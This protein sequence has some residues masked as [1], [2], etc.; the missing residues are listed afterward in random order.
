MEYIYKLGGVASILVVI[1]S[2]IGFCFREKIKTYFQKD[3]IK[4]Q[5]KCVQD[6]ETYKMCLIRDLEK[7][8]LD[9]DVRKSM[10]IEMS[11]KK[12]GAYQK[13]ITGLLRFSNVV[14]T[15]NNLPAPERTIKPFRDNLNKAWQFVTDL[16]ESYFYYA[17]KHR[18][19]MEPLAKAM[20]EIFD[21]TKT[22]KLIDDTLSEQYKDAVK[23]LKRSFISEI[24]PEKFEPESS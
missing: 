6:L 23:E 21:I 3:L 17:E 11:N 10:A 14:H 18:D 20:Q 12:L 4:T 5:N 24:F 1:G 16:E 2:F 22:G 7:Y 8:K 13:T 9:I 19:K 15:Y